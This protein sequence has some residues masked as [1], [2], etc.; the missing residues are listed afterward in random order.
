MLEASP[1][2][3]QALPEAVIIALDGTSHC[4]ASMNRLLYSA[5][6]QAITDEVDVNTQRF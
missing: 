4:S 1:K 5:W 2:P 3:L 6:S